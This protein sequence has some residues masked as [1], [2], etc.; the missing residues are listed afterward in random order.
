MPNQ[1]ARDLRNNMTDAERAIWRLLRQRQIDGH[2]FRRQVTIGPYI[3]DF[4][5][6]EAKLV[7]EIDGGQH[8]E[9]Q[10]YDATRD[11][12]FRDQGFRVLRF[13][14][15]DV[16]KNPEGVISVIATALSQASKSA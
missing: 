5:C 6:L 11:A 4:V 12:L 15:N 10:S 2:R 16:L 8:A 7:I 14:N 9:Q 3:A 1:R 13:W